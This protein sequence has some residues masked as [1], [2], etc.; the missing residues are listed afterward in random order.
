METLFKINQRNPLKIAMYWMRRVKGSEILSF[1]FLHATQVT[2]IFIAQSK[3]TFKGGNNPAFLM[4][5][6]VL[7]VAI[8]LR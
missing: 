6:K 1:N 8:H 2:E 7:V 3:S 4:T 5:R